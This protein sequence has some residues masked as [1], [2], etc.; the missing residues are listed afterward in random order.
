MTEVLVGE[1]AWARMLAHPGATALGALRDAAAALPALPRW[2]VLARACMRAGELGG[3]PL[4]SA[5]CWLW[6]QRLLPPA[7]P[8][9]EPRS[10][11]ASLRATP[12]PL[13]VVGCPLSVLPPFPLQIVVLP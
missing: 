10:P 1:M 9:H 13:I 11:L 7:H 2:V 6:V 8:L 4:T 12:L 5:G 3:M